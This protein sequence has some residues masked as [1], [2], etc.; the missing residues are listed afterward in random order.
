MDR[1]EVTVETFGGE[2]EVECNCGCGKRHRAVRGQ[3]ARAGGTEKVL[4]YALMTEGGGRRCV[5]LIVGSGPWDAG[6]DPRECFCSAQLWAA[7][8]T[9][10][11]RVTDAAECPWRNEPMFTESVGR[12]LDRDEV[13]R[14][15]GG[16]EWL[17]GWTDGL[18]MRGLPRL[19]R[20]LLGSE[21]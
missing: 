13:M 2:R 10:Q 3:A 17:F 20:F 5:W 18:T 11:T 19:G 16:Y 7:D 4:F 6:T 8:G 12:L 9:I 1:G 21:A 15:P 14:K